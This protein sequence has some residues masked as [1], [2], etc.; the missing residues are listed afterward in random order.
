M[1]PRS[2]MMTGQINPMT[3]LDEQ[4]TSI[5]HQPERQQLLLMPLKMSLINS[6]VHILQRDATK[7]PM[8]NTQVP[9]S[10]GSKDNFHNCENLLLNQLP[11]RTRMASLKSANCIFFRIFCV[12]KQS[13]FG[14]HYASLPE[15]P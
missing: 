7:A 6:P 4:M 11:N 13:I 14:K 3:R 10:R 8:V 2:H 15:R 12:T 1:N 5:A 9:S